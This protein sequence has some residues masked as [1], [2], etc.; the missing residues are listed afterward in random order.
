MGTGVATEAEIP[1][2]DKALSARYRM[3]SLLPPSPDGPRS[4]STR[5]DRT[6]TTL[7]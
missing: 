3:A 1:L 7:L 2:W 5:F 6:V 4:W